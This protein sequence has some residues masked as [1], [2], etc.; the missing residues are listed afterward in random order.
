MEMTEKPFQ[1]SRAEGG[2]VANQ[3]TVSMLTVKL[4]FSALIKS[5]NFETDF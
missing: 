2:T 4:T 1:E 5:A 3:E